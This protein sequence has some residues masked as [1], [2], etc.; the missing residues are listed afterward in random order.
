M[1][2][3]AL[4]VTS[5]Q[6]DRGSQRQYFGAITLP[7]GQAIPSIDVPQTGVISP[8][9]K[10]ST[11]LLW[12]TGSNGA[13]YI[14]TLVEPQ[15]ST[16]RLNTILSD[17]NAAMD[18]GELQI[19]SAI[20][21]AHIFLNRSG[22]VHITSGSTKEEIVI[23][24]EQVRLAGA[25]IDIHGNS[26][27]V[28][29][30]HLG[31]EASELGF[32]G[33]AHFGLRTPAPLGASVNLSG[34]SVDALGDVSMSAGPQLTPTGSVSVGI[35]GGAKLE[36]GVGS[37]TLL[38]GLGSVATRI[39][40]NVAL[41]NK[42]RSLIDMDI[43]GGISIASVDAHV[44]IGSFVGVF[45]GLTRRLIDERF[46]ELFYAHTHIS[47]VPGAPTSIVTQP[48][49]APTFPTPG[50]TLAEATIDPRILRAM[51]SITRAD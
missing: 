42:G 35:L 40:G 44:D 49:V 32:P 45:L 17:G 25:V 16:S 11:V 2:T 28:T 36:S 30:T 13:K 47:G 8:P 1:L 22:G 18:P 15:N 43:L 6:Q 14:A 23:D 29:Q 9:L 21:G 7:E 26:A 39:D 31:I 37:G 20:G 5:I 27:V 41:S 51:T 46:L 38:G 10:G 3:T 19:A 50:Y 34:F 12:I 33:S 24:N 4:V 48:I